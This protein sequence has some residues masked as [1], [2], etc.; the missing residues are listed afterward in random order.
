MS[1]GSRNMSYQK[2]INKCIRRKMKAKFIRTRNV[3]NFITT[4][5]NLHNRA[6]GVPG[7][8]LIYGE[9]G[10]GKTQSALWWA[11]NN[12]AS[13]V[14]AKQSMS[15]RWLLRSEEHTSELQSPD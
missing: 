15:V 1:L 11:A 8:A 7:M 12:D 3:K 5:N 10:L 2:N 6:A 4:I 9:P 13:W 14:S